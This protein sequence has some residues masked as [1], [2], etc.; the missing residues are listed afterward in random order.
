MVFNPTDICSKST[1]NASLDTDL[2]G[3]YPYLPAGSNQNDVFTLLC[4]ESA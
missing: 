1:K 2:G 3:N 4:P